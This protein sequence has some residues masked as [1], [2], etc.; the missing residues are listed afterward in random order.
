MLILISTFEIWL[1]YQL[2]FGTVL[3]KEYLL[4][5]EWGIIWGNIAVMGV[6]LGINRSLTFF[7]QDIFVICIVFNCICILFIKKQH[8][9]TV[10]V[11]IILS[12]IIPKVV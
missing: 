8:K 4:K 7:S 12:Y 6:L 1:L 5:R 9:K 10:V 3:D 11:I 2:L